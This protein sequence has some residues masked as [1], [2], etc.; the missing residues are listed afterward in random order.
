MFDPNKPVK[1]QTWARD[2]DGLKMKPKPSRIAYKFFDTNV[3]YGRF[4][5]EIGVS[6][7]FGRNVE[8][9]FPQWSNWD[10]CFYAG[11]WMPE[12]EGDLVMC[13]NG[14]HYCPIEGLPRWSTSGDI[15]F[16]IEVGP[17]EPV[18]QRDLNGKH[19]PI[20]DKHDHIRIDGKWATRTYRILEHVTP[21]QGELKEFFDAMGKRVEGL[22]SFTSLC[23]RVM[24]QTADAKFAGQRTPPLVVA[25]RRWI[26]NLRGR[27]L[28]AN[29]SHRLGSLDVSTTTTT[30]GA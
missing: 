17:P 21:D 1:V 23:A 15:L 6:H 10:S 19:V 27:Q 18:Y 8:I 7:P 26:T 3:S 4:L 14:Y 24:D 20:A 13:S 12:V 11:K 25:F 29:L 16:R 2:R 5:P 30:T 9:E 22:E 28:R